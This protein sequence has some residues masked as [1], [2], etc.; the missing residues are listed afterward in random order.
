M[1]WASS[2]TGCRRGGWWARC[3]P[4]NTTSGPK[5][6]LPHHPQRRRQRGTAGA[7]YTGR[8]GLININEDDALLHL[9]TGRY[10]EYEGCR[11]H[12][13]CRVR[14]CR[15]W[16]GRGFRLVRDLPGD[17]ESVGAGAVGTLGTHG[18]VEA[19]CAG[20]CP[21]VRRTVVPAVPAL[22]VPLNQ[23]WLRAVKQGSMRPVLLPTMAFTSGRHS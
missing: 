18:D 15:G 2:P 21:V 20:G 22:A 11:A 9:L 10:L 14:S 17:A 1:W 4:S 16:P 6:A 12:S 8:S 13:V 3:W 19:A 23:V 5:P 7:Q